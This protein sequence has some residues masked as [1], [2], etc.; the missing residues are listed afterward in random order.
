MEINKN[1]QKYLRAKKKVGEMKRFYTNLMMYIFFICALA[2]LN[3]YTNQFSNPWFLWA[4]LGWGIGIFFQVIKVFN[5]TP[6]MG[7]NWEE[8]KL[9]QFMDEENNKN[10]WE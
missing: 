5:W 8:R 3:Y 2:G 10:P 4:A 7:S 1:D 9:K 6:F